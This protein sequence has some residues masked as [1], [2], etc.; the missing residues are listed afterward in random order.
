LWHGYRRRAGW[1]PFKARWRSGV[2]AIRG[3]ERAFLNKSG[4]VFAWSDLKQYHVCRDEVSGEI[5]AA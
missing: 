2:D 5:H 3:R 4:P 1:A